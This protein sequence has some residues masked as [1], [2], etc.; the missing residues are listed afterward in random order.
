MAKILKNNTAQDVPID[1]L[2]I[3]VAASGQ[4]DIDDISI[5]KVSTSDDLIALLADDTL[6]A[7]DGTRDLSLSDA[8]HHL[9][10]YIQNH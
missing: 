7:N 10:G 8:V 5:N 6:T 2:G 9:F 3:V 4:R 1:D